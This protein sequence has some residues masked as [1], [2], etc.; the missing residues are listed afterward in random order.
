MSAFQNVLVGLDLL[1]CPKTDSGD[2]GPSA[3]KAIERALMV[4]H[5]HGSRLLFFSAIELAEE[6][7]HLLPFH[8]LS[9]W[10]DSVFE[11]CRGILDRLVRNARKQG[12]EAAS[13]LVQG[14]GWLE[15][16]RQVIH[17]KHDLVIV[18]TRTLTGLRRVLFANTAMKLI[19]VC[20][21]PVWV[22]HT[23]T[24]TTP[25][26]I[27]V[28]T[29]LKKGAE[30]VLRKGIEI[31]AKNGGEIHVLHVLEYPLDRV[32]STGLP[33]LAAEDY[34]DR[35]RAAANERLQLL[36]AACECPGIRERLQIHMV[37]GVGVPDVAIQQ[38]LHLLQIDL[39]I[40]GT[41]AR[42]GV[43]GFF[44]G[45][46]AERLVPEVHCSLLVFKSSDFHFPLLE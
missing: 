34:H 20:P 45:N 7:F 3:Q 9:H 38:H 39:L 31:G 12:I 15:I 29:D 33:D 1:H 46:T 37:D 32:W 19:R 13:E 11:S 27:L 2:L 41:T 22:T 42:S 6:Y 35:I 21:C 16:T 44:L 10:K 40:M 5:E 17:H 43:P 8:Y 18:G 28:A 36:L 25:M 4:A 30:E 24:Q 14:R 26:N 23:G